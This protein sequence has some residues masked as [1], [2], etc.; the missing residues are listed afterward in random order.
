MEG[1][2]PPYITSHTF[3]SSTLPTHVVHERMIV[4]QLSV[5]LEIRLRLVFFGERSASNSLLPYMSTEHSFCSNQVFCFV[6]F[7]CMTFI[8]PYKTGKHSASISS[9]YW[10]IYPHQRAVILRGGHQLPDHGPIQSV[11]VY[12]FQ[13]HRFGIVEHTR[14]LFEEMTERSS[15]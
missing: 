3:K 4:F 12:V 13:A 6:R 8:Q 10:R 1:A 7:T 11:G 2:P 15:W 5:T 9:M 14:R